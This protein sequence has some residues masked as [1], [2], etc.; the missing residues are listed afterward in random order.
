MISED[1]IKVAILKAGYEYETDY[2]KLHELTFNLT[3]LNIIKILK[4]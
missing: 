1:P 4:G 3:R 2:T